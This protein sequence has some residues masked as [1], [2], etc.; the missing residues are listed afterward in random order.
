MQ[1]RPGSPSG[2]FHQHLNLKPLLLAL[3]LLF[4]L[5]FLGCAP[6]AE[7]EASVI[8]GE[9]PLTVSFS[10][11][12]KNATEFQ[13]DFGD[14]AT[15]TTGTIEKLVTHEY[16]KAGVHTVTLTAGKKGDP[17]NASTMTLT[18]TVKHG[19]LDRVKLSPETVELDIGESQE[20]SA[21][22]VDA[23]DNPIP[24]AELTWEVAD[25]AGTITRRGKLTAGT[26]ADA[27]P[28][29]VVVIAELDTHT[30][31]ATAPVTVNPDPLEAV[32]ISHI[33]VAAGETQQLEAIARDQHGN[34]LSDVDAAWTA[35]DEEAGSITGAGLFTAG[36]V[37]R[38][39]ADAVEV[40]VT[41][42]EL[43]RTAEA[44]V[45]ITPGPLDQV[46]IAPDRAEIGMEMTQ[47]FVAVGA[48][49][50][51]NRI[52]GLDFTWSVEN[53]GGTID[54]TGLFTAGTTP[55]T[56]E[57]TV[58]AE[59]TE[60]GT[61]RSAT[62]GVT[63]ETDRIVFISDR[64]DDQY[65]LYIMDVDGNNIEQLTF[66]GVKVGHHTCSPDGRRVAYNVGDDILTINDDGTWNMAVLSGREA[67]EPAWSPDGSKIAF[68]S[69]E[70]QPSEIYVMDVDGGNL[71]R[72]TY[73]T[74][75]DDYPAWSP[76]GTQIVFVSDRDGNSEIYVMDADGSNQRRLTN[77]SADDWF[78]VWSP[79]GKEILFQSDRDGRG[80]YVM[81]ADGTSVRRL[82]STDYS[83]NCPFWSPDGTKIVFHSWQDTDQSEIYI[84]DRDGSDI[85]RLTSDSAIDYH[86]RWMPRKKG[87]DVTKASVI[88]PDTST[89][90]AM[91]SQDVTALARAAV[92]RIETDLSGGSGFFINSDGLILTNNH[93]IR[94]A[95]EITVYL[96][97]GT[98]YDGT[99]KARDLV[100]DLALVKIKATGLPYLEIGD[101]SEVALGEQV[102]V[103]GYPLGGEN[104]SV[105]S[106]LV[107]G[108]EFDGGRNVTWVQTDSAVN[109]GNS[110]G[111]MLTLQGKVIG[112]VAAKIM[113]VAVEG[114]GFAISANTVNL[115]LPLLEAGETIATFS[116][117]ISGALEVSPAVTATCPYGSAGPG[118]LTAA[119]VFIA[120]YRHRAVRHEKH[121]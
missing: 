55:D 83:S 15:M 68:Q 49:R 118:S 50:Y 87:V 70:H 115:Y 67:Y 26:K 79:D 89:H 12:S 120:I 100:R 84:M 47:Q 32:T 54:G 59:A 21:E 62:V 36:E 64:N 94:D 16:T 108:I 69:W 18:I 103:L 53:G 30:A 27:F 75:Y 41:Q 72:L 52:S 121:P 104:V 111:P 113:H 71:T 34:R 29:G 105:T 102:L 35:T 95:D 66:G 33:K 76:D 77:D 45:I 86:P 14:G 90:K 110:G 3:L 117:E 2:I 8:S 101:L 114:M 65:D 60:G 81:N 28:E 10:N 112:V 6:L 22:A 96:E 73:D 40:E 44:H 38:S 1:H 4:I 24:E 109:P 57:D 42:G 82:T 74:D 31:A 11:T 37:A 107:S 25:D 56:Y 63:V 116:A 46:V 99:V 58:K 9:A 78:P 23:Y 61:T 85:T 39:Y 48:D 106:G 51:G 80:I 43:V 93:V 20:F 5:P 119:A 98:S 19:S 91:T 13:W 88:V 97:D 92:V 17:S 7:V